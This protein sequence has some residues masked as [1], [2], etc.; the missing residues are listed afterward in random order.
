M[1]C[2]RRDIIALAGAI[3]FSAVP[4]AFGIA[5]KTIDRTVR[6]ENRRYGLTF[7]AEVPN[8][9]SRYGHAFIVWQREDDSKR[10]SVADAIGFYP[11]GEPKDI[12][13]L[14]G[15]AGGLETDVNTRADLKLTVLLNSDLYRA[16]LDRKAMWMANGRYRFLWRNCTTHV[17][18]IARSI[19]LNSSKGTW[20]T[21]QSY[22]KDLMDNNN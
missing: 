12:E 21:P 15:T 1:I 6:S 19:S 4:P 2:T 7:V 10:M 9:D 3:V 13:V 22:L 11:V 17:A 20:E 18:E 16:A 5:A 14:F 8:D